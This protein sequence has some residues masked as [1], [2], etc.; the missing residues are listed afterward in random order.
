MKNN[1]AAIQLVL[2]VAFFFTYIQAL[3]AQDSSDK[4]NAFALW[5]SQE[6]T[7]DGSDKEWQQS[8]SFIDNKADIEY[9]FSNND[10][11]F[12]VCLKVKD[13]LTKTKIL[14]AGLVLSVNREGK[15]KQKCSILFPIKNDEI[16]VPQ[17]PIQDLKTMQMLALINAKKYQIDGFDNGDGLYATN[18][19]NAAGIRITIGFNDSSEL[20]YEAEIPFAAFYKKAQLSTEDA[21]KPVAVCI[22]VNGLSKPSMPTDG[23]PGGGFPPPPSGGAPPQSG[24]LRTPPGGG[25]NGGFEQ[26]NRLFQSTKTWK[27]IWLAKK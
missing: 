26:M 10:S 21:G 27:I 1:F 2:P 13:E 11:S 24:A 7:I 20:I 16:Q 8:H 4:K 9:Y 3:K 14:N 15:K 25:I 18:E 6:I 17:G 5:Q 22:T 23:A 12:Y 19:T